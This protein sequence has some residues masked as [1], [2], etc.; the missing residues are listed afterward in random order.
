MAQ[1]KHLFLAGAAL[2]LLCV[3]Q[4]PSAE[5]RR[6]LEV[7]AFCR[8]SSHP[9]LCT[10]MVNGAKNWH[11]ASANAMKAALTVAKRLQ[12][13]APQLKPAVSNLLPVSRES[14]M[15]TCVEDFDTIVS[16]LEESIK[17]LDENDKGTLL[18][19]LSAA[20]NSDCEDALNEFGAD[21]PLSKIAG[22]LAKEVDN[23]LAVVQQI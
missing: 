13:M 3:T 23:C 9:Q 5:A 10:K 18:A 7:N 6:L 8:T 16:D 14:I 2:L 12:S 17:A 15:S 1:I 19:H 11:D 20:Y 21:F 22:Y 4:T